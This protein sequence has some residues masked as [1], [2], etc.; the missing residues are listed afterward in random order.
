MASDRF[1]QRQ[2]RMK[3][4]LLAPGLFDSVVKR[5]HW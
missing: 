1:A 5:Y 2:P 3:E 4:R